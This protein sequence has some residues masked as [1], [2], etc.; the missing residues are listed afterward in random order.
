MIDIVFYAG[1]VVRAQYSGRG[2]CGRG[3]GKGTGK[4]GLGA[5]LG[6]NPARGL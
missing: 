2:G 3:E 1:V 4:G 6:R 5:S